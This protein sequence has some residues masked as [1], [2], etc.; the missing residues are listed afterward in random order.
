MA[1]YVFLSVDETCFF[2]L[3]PKNKKQKNKTVTSGKIDKNGMV[4]ISD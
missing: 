2:F 3:E 1:S 4:K